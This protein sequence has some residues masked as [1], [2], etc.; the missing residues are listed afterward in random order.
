MRRIRFNELTY[1][2]KKKKDIVPFIFWFRDED[3]LEEVRSIIAE[4][5][6]FVTVR[7]LT[8]N[9]FLRSEIV[10]DV[11]SYKSDYGL[12]VAKKADM[13]KD[14]AYDHPLTFLVYEIDRTK[15]KGSYRRIVT[16]IKEQLRR[17]LSHLKG[18]DQFLLVHTPDFIEEAQYLAT[19]FLSPLNQKMLRLRTENVAQHCDFSEINAVLKKERLA[20]YNIIVVGSFPLALTG[21][22]SFNAVDIDFVYGRLRRCLRMR[23]KRAQ[24]LSQGVD[25][26]SILYTRDPAISDAIH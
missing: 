19:Y 1:C 10:K 3:I 6:D 14:A 8:Y 15:V 17:A 22:V 26:A 20:R 11:Y 16:Q 23:K 4:R 7:R 18:V 12:S 13:V 2:T 21:I 24:P 9:A 25:L 5:L